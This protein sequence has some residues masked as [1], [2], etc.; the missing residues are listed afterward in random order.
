M[1]I[2]GLFSAIVYR[3][4]STEIERGVRRQAVR[5]MP[6]PGNVFFDEDSRQQII[7]EAKQRVLFELF[8]I[9][10]GILILSGTAGYFLAGK[11]LK[12]ISEMVEEQRR[13]VADASH[14]LRTPLTVLKTETEVAL[15][16]KKLTVSSAKKLLESSLEEIDKL[17][18]L[19]DYFLTLNKYQDSTKTISFEI[20]D[21]GD[22]ARSVI[23]KLSPVAKK[24]KIE[25]VDNI[26]SVNIRANKISMRE[27][28]TILVDNAIKYSFDEGKVI[29]STFLKKNNV[30]ITVEDFGLGIKNS[31]LPFIFNRFYRADFSRTR[32]ESS[33]YGLGLSIARS[34]LDM[35]KGKIE[36]KSNVG[37]GSIFTVILPSN[38]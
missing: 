38:I 1:I 26:Q 24:R 3:I 8:A 6:L 34:I 31:D 22:V 17:K 13:F 2:S 5:M 30:I 4:V 15:L 10:A 18:K 11:T 12:P 37:K 28:I 9:N 23:S 36:V 27:L 25:I 33:G 32:N 29:I 20:F 7:D 14:E 19:T 21:L 35:H 16:D